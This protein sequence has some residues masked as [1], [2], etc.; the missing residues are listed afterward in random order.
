VLRTRLFDPLGMADTGFHAAETT[1]LATAYQRVDGRL[2]VSDG[3]DGQWSKPPAFPDGGGG[4]VSCADDMIAFGR[5]P[6][7]G[8]APVLSQATVIAMT[9]DRLTPAQRANVWPGFN[10]LDGRGRGYGVSVPDDGRYTWDGGFGTTWSN[11][12]SQ[13]LTVV[14]LTQRTADE[15]GMPAVCENVLTAARAG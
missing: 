4:L 1:R 9:R 10:F 8:G 14:V 13:D 2:E 12:P 3:P 5:M 15:T 7:R 6:A 11:V